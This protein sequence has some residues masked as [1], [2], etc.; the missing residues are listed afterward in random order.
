MVKVLYGT[1]AGIVIGVVGFFGFQ[2]YTQ[3]RVAS[4]IEAA[5]DQIRATGAKASHGKV[6]FD[7]KSRTVTV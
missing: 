4:E 3:Y 5:F 7:L 2:F 1:L 6:S